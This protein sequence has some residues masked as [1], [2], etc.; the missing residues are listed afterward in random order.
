MLQP[1]LQLGGVEI[2]AVAAHGVDL[3][4]GGGEGFASGFF[5]AFQ[6]LQLRGQEQHLVPGFCA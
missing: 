4:L 1:L 6:E 2:P 5:A 3:L